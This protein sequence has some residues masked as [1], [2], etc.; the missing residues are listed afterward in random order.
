V[1]SK[2]GYARSASGNFFASNI[3]DKSLRSNALTTPM[4]N[5]AL[6]RNRRYVRAIISINEGQNHWGTAQLVVNSRIRIN[7]NWWNFPLQLALSWRVPLTVGV[8]RKKQ[9]RI[10]T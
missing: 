10:F 4:K 9:I 1:G 8:I 5:A 3:R 7:K 6:R 2:Y